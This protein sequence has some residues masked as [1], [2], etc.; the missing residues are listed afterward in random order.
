[1]KEALVR[2]ILLLLKKFGKF[3][4]QLAGFAGTIY[5]KQITDKDIAKLL[6]RN[7]YRVVMQKTDGGCLTHFP[8]R[9][10]L[11]VQ[12]FSRLYQEFTEDGILEATHNE[13]GEEIESNIIKCPPY[14]HRLFTLYNVIHHCMEI[15]YEMSLIKFV[16]DDNEVPEEAFFQ[17]HVSPFMDNADTMRE[18]TLRNLISMCFQQQGFLP[19]HAQIAEQE[20]IHDGF[21]VIRRLFV[22]DEM[23]KQLLEM[24]GTPDHE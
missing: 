8:H 1:M 20:G 3:S 16:L 11:P 15:D 4:G 6:D 14:A 23:I 24:I 19:H 18:N 21:I 12:V 9:S 7:D 22:S 10:E 13:M 2:A 5:M 17:A